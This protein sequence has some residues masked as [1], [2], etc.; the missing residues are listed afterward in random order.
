[1]TPW[2]GH[3]EDLTLPC[4]VSKS[5]IEEH[6]SVLIPWERT[7][8]RWE[9]IRIDLYLERWGCSV[10]RL[11]KT[12]WDG[13]IFI[14]NIN[15]VK[16]TIHK[17]ETV[18]LHFNL[19]LKGTEDEGHGTDSNLFLTLLPEAILLPKFLWKPDLNNGND[20]GDQISLHQTGWN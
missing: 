7:E 18:K 19:R 16:R 17:I 1:M 12:N 15:S 2:F 9:L 11:T 14:S 3:R 5:S 4:W 8:S 20:L 6:E 13:I 10:H